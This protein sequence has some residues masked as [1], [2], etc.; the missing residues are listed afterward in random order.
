MGNAKNVTLSPL[1]L[2]SK[3]SWSLITLPVMGFVNYRPPQTDKSRGSPAFYPWIGI[4]ARTDA[5]SNLKARR[6]CESLCCSH[7]PRTIYLICFTVGRFVAEDKAV[8]CWIWRKLDTQRVKLNTF[9]INNEDPFYGISW[10]SRRKQHGDQR[11]ASAHRD[12]TTKAEGE[13]S[14]DEWGDARSRFS[15]LE[16]ELEVS[17]TSMLAI[18]SLKGEDL[19]PC[20]GSC[21]RMPLSLTAVVLLGDQQ[22]DCQDFNQTISNMFEIIGVALMSP[23]ATQEF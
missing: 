11:S 22:C 4:I 6:L 13:T 21:S 12:K 17:V 16:W 2:Q 15:V 19:L 5:V 8:W 1:S 10:G 9:G 20:P 23:R 18:I 14:L 3:H 7:I